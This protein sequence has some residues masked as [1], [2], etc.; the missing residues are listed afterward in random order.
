MASP[1]EALNNCTYTGVAQTLGQA[2]VDTNYASMIYGTYACTPFKWQYL[3]MLLCVLLWLIAA[4]WIYDFYMRVRGTA[5]GFTTLADELTKKDN[6][7]LAIDF[8]SFLLS[9][10]IITR[11]SLTDLHPGMGNDALYFG[12]FFIYQAIGC[13]VLVVSRFLNDKLMLRRADNLKEML[14]HR[15]VAVGTVEAGTTIATAIIFSASGSGADVNLGEGIAATLV[16]WIV[17]QVFLISYGN[18]VDLITSIPM[19]NAYQ[20]ELVSGTRTD[21]DQP[22]VASAGGAP[23]AG[24]TAGSSA[25][26]AGGGGGGERTGATSLLKE[27]AAGNCA[28]GL[29][30]AFDLIHAGVLIA[31]PIY[32]GYS[33]VAWLIWVS[34]TLGVASP[35]MHLYLD[36]IIL[37]GVSYSTNILRDKN[38]GAAGLMGSQKLLLS[39]VLMFSYRENCSPDT[40]LTDCLVKQPDGMVERLG[41]VSVPNVFT[42]QVL[43]NLL[44]LLLLVGT[45]KFLYFVRFA[46]KDGFGKAR[47]HAHS[48]SL[49]ATLGDPKNNSVCISM[50]AFSFAAGLTIVGVVTCPNPV[51]GLHAAESLAWI[52]IGLVLLLLALLIN[53]LVLLHGVHNSDMLIA[54]NVAIATF[55]AGSFLACGLL[56]RTTLTGDG[57]GF[58]D[59]LA[60]TCLYWALAQF[61]LL[62]FCYIYRFLTVF[63]D[64][65]ALKEGNVAAGLSGGLTLVA[66]A[67]VMSF[68]IMYFSSILLFLPVA[69]TGTVVLMIIRKLSDKFIL[70]GDALDK[71]IG[72]DQNW[73]AALIEGAVAVGLAYISNSY[74]PPPGAP[75]VSSDIDY[76]DVCD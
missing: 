70:P 46:V 3:V 33:I 75:F 71:E 56:L 57:Y 66:L 4:R 21:V 58:A 74:V 19:L 14:A 27:A 23:D 55:E 40:L 35:V 61:L 76:F 34:M 63:D 28:A 16:Y 30:L 2:L 65:L 67:I 62:V 42:W 53:D 7:A 43:V 49:D 44:L 37:R 45:T 64:H 36:Q 11:G 52:A 18:L 17:G 72:N 60:L 48:F 38:W 54:D 59:G 31:A 68:P 29:S 20:A 10:C 6:P 15:S 1:F 73:G 32:A 8:A 24:D 26:I 41:V 9:I 51:A 69:L 39:L 13:V 50:A 22:A 12:S 5:Y 47:E 25:P